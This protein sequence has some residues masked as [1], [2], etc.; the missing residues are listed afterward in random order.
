M[1]IPNELHDRVWEGL[2]LDVIRIKALARS[3]VLWP[4]IN[5]QLEELAKACSLCQQNQNMPTKALLDP[6]D[7]PTPPWQPINIDYAGPLQNVMFLVVVNAHST[8]A[9]MIAVSST[10]SKFQVQPLKSNAIFSPDFEFLNIS[11]VTMVNNLFLGSSR[12][13][14]SPVASA[15]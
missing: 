6:R 14:S 2:Q 5:A 15:M 10:T 12:R 3:Y 11:L 4:N 7:W 8:W 9:E 1:V 13:S